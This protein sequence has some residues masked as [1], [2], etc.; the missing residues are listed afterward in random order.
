MLGFSNQT[1]ISK[2]QTTKKVH[3]WM[4]AKKDYFSE[5]TTITYHA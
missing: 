5:H 1:I 4:G 2:L 3:R